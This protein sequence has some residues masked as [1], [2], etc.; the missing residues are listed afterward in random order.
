MRKIPLGTKGAFNIRVWPEHLADQFKLAV[1][2]QI[3][4]GE[5]GRSSL[6]QQSGSY[7]PNVF[8]P[9][10]R[11]GPNQFALIPGRPGRRVADRQFWSGIVVPLSYCGKRSCASPEG[12]ESF[13]LSEGCRHGRGVGR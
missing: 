7:R 6:D 2:G 8:W 1:D 3:E 9:Q 10:W 13:R 11:L 12:A 5:V 4:Q